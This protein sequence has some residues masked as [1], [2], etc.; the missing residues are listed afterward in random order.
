[1]R[2]LAECD[3]REIDL[4]VRFWGNVKKEEDEK[5]IAYSILDWERMDIDAL[6]VKCTSHLSSEQEV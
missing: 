2:T 5:R 1:M 4:W 6:L 3:E